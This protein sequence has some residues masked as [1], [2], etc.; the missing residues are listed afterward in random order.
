MMMIYNTGSY[1]EYLFL[2][3]INEVSNMGRKVLIVTGVNNVPGLGEIEKTVP[4]TELSASD[5]EK[6]KMNERIILDKNGNIVK[7][8]TKEDLMSLDKELE[9][10]FGPA[11]QDIQLAQIGEG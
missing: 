1:Q 8:I 6:Y 5:M 9:K 11:Q 4:F 7:R 2:K 10:K 3:K